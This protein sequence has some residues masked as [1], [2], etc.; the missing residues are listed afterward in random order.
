MP[1]PGPPAMCPGL[2]FFSRRLQWHQLTDDGRHHLKRGLIAIGTFIGL[3][4]GGIVV[5]VVAAFL[6]RV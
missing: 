1:A 6:M 4:V 2:H 5:G 3:C